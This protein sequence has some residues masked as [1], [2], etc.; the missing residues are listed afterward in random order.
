M[1]SSWCMGVQVYIFPK[2]LPPAAPPVGKEVAQIKQ[3][4]PDGTSKRNRWAGPQRGQQDHCLLRCARQKW[5]SDAQA[6]QNDLQQV[7]KCAYVYP[8]CQKQDSLRVNIPPA[9]SSSSGSAMVRLM[10]R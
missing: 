1:P 7:A 9:A 8:D 5:R 2:P 3:L 4:F 10:P 6:L